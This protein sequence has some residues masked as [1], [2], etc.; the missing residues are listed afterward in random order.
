MD[1]VPAIFC[2]QRTNW[3]VDGWLISSIPTNDPTTVVGRQIPS[4]GL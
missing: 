1:Q 4:N 2:H 3:P